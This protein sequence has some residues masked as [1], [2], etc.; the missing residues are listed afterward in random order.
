MKTRFAIAASL[1]AAII[2]IGCTTSQQT[3]AFNT[4]YSLSHGVNSAYS[5]YCDGIIAGTYS[6]NSNPTIAK[7][8]NDYQASS[9]V[10]LDA[11]QYNTNALA[12]PALT[13]EAQDVINLITAAKK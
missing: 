7:A 2:I 11:V 6:T 10:A 12:P 4:I 3:A 9:L 13:T 1:L 5:A 8:F